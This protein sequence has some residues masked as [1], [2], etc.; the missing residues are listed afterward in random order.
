MP[1]PVGI[2][3]MDAFW[4]RLKQVF[5]ILITAFAI[6]LGAPFWFDLLNKFM[7]IRSTVKPTEK[8]PE[9]GSEDRAK[10]KSKSS[11][12]DATAAAAAAAAA[13]TAAT[14]SKTAADATGES[15]TPLDTPAM[16]AATEI[17]PPFTA[18]EWAVGQ[19]QE[20]IL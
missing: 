18:Q 20:G 10:G 15:A 5:G 4:F 3:G 2:T 16:S 8:S 7:V 14:R 11:T 1:K 6:M 12:S 9:E 19:P 13:A 17:E